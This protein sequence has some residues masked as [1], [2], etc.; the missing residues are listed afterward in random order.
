[1]TRKEEIEAY[2]EDIKIQRN[3]LLQ[4]LKVMP[5]SLDAIEEKLY[6]I[7]RLYREEKVDNEL[8]EVKRERI[9]LPYGIAKPHFL[10]PHREGED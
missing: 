6:K 2:I 10:K 3:N 5:M 8:K 7:E 9:D 4:L 1:M